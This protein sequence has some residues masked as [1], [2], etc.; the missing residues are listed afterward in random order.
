MKKLAIGCLVVFVIGAAAAVVGG[1][2]VY[3]K[4]RSTVTQLAE[5]RQIPE[6]EQG[7]RVKT[8][9]TAPPSGDLTTQQLDKFM[10][11]QATVR[12]RLGR[13]MDALQR[14][15]KSLSNKKDATI[16]DL[17]QIL[18]AY[19]DVA[20]SWLD[21]K[22]TQVVALNDAGLS[23]DEY[24]WIRS[25]AYQAL[26]VPFIAI[27]FAQLAEQTKAG[28]QP[29]DALFGN[30]YTGPVSPAT[31]TLVEKYRDRLMDNLPIASFGL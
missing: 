13:N 22:R 31:A 25:R 19:R 21:A 28:V 8:P 3:F 16:T 10:K 20:A 24:R 1:Y 15:Y 30:A 4:V 18:S 7:V 11:V 29:G 14:N 27:D 2:Y 12:D 9:F 23:I 26:N 5:L 6:I 17:P